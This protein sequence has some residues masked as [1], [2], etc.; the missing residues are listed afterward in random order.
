MKQLRETGSKIVAT[1]EQAKSLATISQLLDVS[2]TEPPMI[3]E[4]EASK[5]I[6]SLSGWLTELDDDKSYAQASHVQSV[7]SGEPPTTSEVQR[8]V[9]TLVGDQPVD[10]EWE[11]RRT[12][13][14]KKKKAEQDKAAIE[15]LGKFVDLTDILPPLPKKGNFRVESI[16]SAQYFF[17]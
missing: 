14:A 6:V 2:E 7:D 16:K 3:D 17:S 15:L 12:K 11:S 8:L 10:D 9:D 5:A 13:A 4:S 1:P